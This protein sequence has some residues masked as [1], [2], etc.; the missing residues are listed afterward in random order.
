MRRSMMSSRGSATGRSFGTSAPSSRAAGIPSKVPVRSMGP[1]RT[2]RAWPS[3]GS[4]RLASNFPSL[5]SLDIWRYQRKLYGTALYYLLAPLRTGTEQVEVRGFGEDPGTLLSHLE[6]RGLFRDLYFSVALA[7]HVEAAV[8]LLEKR[9][10]KFIQRWFQRSGLSPDDASDASKDV[11]ADCLLD[12]CN[13]F[14]RGTLEGW[15]LTICRRRLEFVRG[16]RRMGDHLDVES[17][18]APRELDEKGAQEASGIYRETLEGMT[19]LQQVLVRLSY[20]QGLTVRQVAAQTGKHYA[21]ISRHLVAARARFRGLLLD[22]TRD[23][24]GSEASDSECDAFLTEHCAHLSFGSAPDAG[25]E[26][27]AVESAP[28]IPAAPHEECP[29]VPGVLPA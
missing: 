6:Q 28:D 26:P 15:V 27:A 4:A 23:Y 2:F 9:H 10:G 24:L 25:S 29:M 20:E 13:Y 17:A 3:S 11:L 1:T 8:T 14:A 5:G 12:G 19:E 7:S 22:R 16:S 21:T 18:V